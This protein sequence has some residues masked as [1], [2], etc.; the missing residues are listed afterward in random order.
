M[1]AITCWKSTLKTVNIIIV[2]KVSW[3]HN[4]SRQCCFYIVN[5]EIIQHLLNVLLT[6]KKLLIWYLAMFWF[7]ENQFLQLIFTQMVQDLQQEVKVCIQYE[8]EC[9]GQGI[10]VW[11][12]SNFLKAVF[13]KFYLVHFWITWPIYFWCFLLLF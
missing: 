7:Q 10:Q 5:F 4:Q 8:L 2:F 1:L 12:E 11:T 13:H 9:L 3:H 6:L